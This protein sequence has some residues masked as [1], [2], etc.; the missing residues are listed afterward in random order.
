MSTI[1]R[2]SRA[3]SARS[4]RARMGRPAVAV[5]AAALTALGALSVTPAPAQAGQGVIVNPS[6]D[7]KQPRILNG[8]VYG[9]DSAGPL[10]VVGGS[11][12]KIR[13][14][15]FGTPE[16]TQQWLFMFN[17]DTGQIV[18][19]FAPQMRGPAPNTSGLVGDRPGVQA[20]EFAADGQSVYVAGDF[21]E[22]NGTPRKRVVRLAL[23]GSII[24]SFTTEANNT[25]NDLALVGNRL[26]LAGRF[27]QL[28]NK[29]V[30]RLGSVDP[31]TGAVQTDFN[32]PITESRYQ[33]ATYVQEI[34]TSAD[35]KWLVLAGNFEKVGAVTRKQLALVS[36]QGTP[37]VANWSTDLYA[38]D[39]AS[40]YDDSWIRGVD[41]SPDS[42][43]FVVSGTGAYRG[44][45]SLCDSAARWELPPTKSGDG[46]LPTWRTLTGG[47]T[48]WDNEITD[49]AVYIGGHHRWV[50]NPTPYPGGDRGRSGCG[51]ALRHRSGR[52]VDRRAALLEPQ[53]GP[54]P[55]RRGALRHR[56]EPLR[57]QR[58]RHLQQRNPPTP[59]RSRPGWR[60]G[61]PTAGGRSASRQPELLGGQ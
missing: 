26:L 41:I 48:F 37:S 42:S 11:F 28:N 36:L 13:N 46:Q 4:L 56:P 25:V 33:Y 52:P 22:V 47:D 24:S 23:D 21:T 12:D 61:Q 50:N 7:Q 8:R 60:Q 51:G 45:D 58:H 59:R 30:T 1:N 2:D 29:E 35:G 40:V 43:Y 6:P 44:A 55:W 39:C 31:A 53:P 38:G 18:D 34:D 32:L 16:R 49:S 15:A 10:V 14:G 9:I 17:S 5:L 54:R 20:V 57:R 3:L 19:S 27:G